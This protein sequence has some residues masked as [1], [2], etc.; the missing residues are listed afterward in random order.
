V[1][2]AGAADVDGLAAML[3]RAFFD[4]PVV[5]WMLP[6]EQRRTKMGARAYRTFLRHI[7]LPTDEVYIDDR[8]RGAALWSPPGRWRVS[9]GAQLRMGPSLLRVFGI[10]RTPL[11][12]RGL[13]EIEVKHPDDVPHWHLGILGTDPVHQGQG[14][15]SSVMAPVL[16]RCDDEQVPAYLESSKHANIA[17]YR[18]HGFEVTGEI[19]IPE[20]PTI[21]GMWREP[22]DPSEN[23]SERGTGGRR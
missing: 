7:Y 21:W 6:D 22:V 17:F 16:A 12:L 11:L 13:H 15:A 20:G 10:R 5:V 8:G 18:R 3:L 14:V 1:R 9:P 23:R 4:D 19:S 2:R